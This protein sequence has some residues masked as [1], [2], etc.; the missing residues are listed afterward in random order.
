MTDSAHEKYAIVAR[1]D[2]LDLRSILSL[3]K[4]RPKQQRS[5]IIVPQ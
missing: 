1:A 3:G 5:S 2:D 4:E